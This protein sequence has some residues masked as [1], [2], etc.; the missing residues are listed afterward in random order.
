MAKKILVIVAH[1]DD[2][3]IWMGG[4]LLRNK[5][6]D[7]KIIT[8]CR[9]NDS[10]RAPKFKKVCRILNASCSM[11]TLEDTKLYP[12]EIE[13]IISRIKK[14]L[15][16]KDYD[17]IFTHGNNGEYGHIRHTEVHRAVNKMIANKELNCKKVFYFSYQKQDKNC[18]INSNA[19]IIIKLNSREF[20]MKQYLIKKIYGFSKDSFEVKS[21][22]NKEAFD[23]R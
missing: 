2:E 7:K 4:L 20:N 10:D 5:S 13:K 9:K 21:S 6:W 23:T 16:N 15:K 17:Y 18:N 3:T 22:H 1:P 8:L 19:D 14:L 12:L 11:S